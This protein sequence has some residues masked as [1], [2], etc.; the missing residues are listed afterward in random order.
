[1]EIWKFELR[2]IGSQMIPIPADA[3]ILSVAVQR[4]NICVW[5]LVD[6]DRPALI[7]K[8]EVIGTGHPM[9]TGV[10]RKFIGT[11]IAEPFV[12]HVFEIL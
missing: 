1:M 4:G 3:E 8:I 7:R 5:A 9:E 10:S 11:V 12:W 2:L 6:P